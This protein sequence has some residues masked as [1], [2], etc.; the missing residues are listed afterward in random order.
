VQR[1]EEGLGQGEGVRSERVAGLQ[2]RGDAGMVVQDRPQPVREDLDLLGP[3]EGPIE[4]VVDLGQ[5]SVQDEIV[6]LLHVAYVAVQRRGNDLE[7]GG[8]CAHAQ[9]VHAVGGDDGKR[10]GNQA[11][12]G[13]GA[14]PVLVD[15]RRGEPQLVRADVASCRSVVWLDHVRLR[16]PR[17]TVNT[18]HSTVNSVTPK[19]MLFTRAASPRGVGPLARPKV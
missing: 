12:A 2:Q 11:F 6:E 9:R 19:R 5:H 3:G 7:T 1:C 17:L 8:Q 16:T 15:H 13:Q 10:L 18:V 4:M 14:A